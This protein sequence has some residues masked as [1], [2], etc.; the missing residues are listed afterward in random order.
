MRVT[1]H[2]LFIQ[3]MWTKT[4][5][6]GQRQLQLPLLAIPGSLFCP[7]QAYRCMCK[8]VPCN[9]CQPAFMVWQGVNK[10]AYTYLQWQTRF[11]CLLARTGRDPAKFSSH[12]FRRGGASFAFQAGVPAATVKLIGDWRSDSFYKY[13]HIPMTAKTLA[14]DRIRRLLSNIRPLLQGD[15]SGPSS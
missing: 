3:F 11:K 4:I 15:H 13:L 12:S 6:F 9:P 2:C 1:S 5:Q 10:V 14:A 8:L 7:V